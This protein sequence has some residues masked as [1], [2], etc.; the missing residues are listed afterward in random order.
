MC[1]SAG[2][3]QRMARFSLGA[4]LLPFGTLL[5]GSTI[6]TNNEKSTKVWTG[7]A[8]NAPVEL[9]AYNSD[10]TLPTNQVYDDIVTD[11]NITAPEV[12]DITDNNHAT[13]KYTSVDRGIT[14]MPNVQAQVV[15]VSLI[16][17]SD[18]SVLNVGYRNDSSVYG[19]Y[20]WIF[21]HT[22]GHNTS[23]VNIASFRAT[24]AVSI[25]DYLSDTVLLVGY[26][27]SSNTVSYVFVNT[28]T[29]SCTSVRTINSTPMTL[30]YAK[31]HESCIYFNGAVYYVNHDSTSTLTVSKFTLSGS[32]F[33]TLALAYNNDTN[34]TGSA[35][36]YLCK[37]LSES[38]NPDK[39]VFIGVSGHVKFWYYTIL[40][41]GESPSFSA[42]QYV[43]Q[44]SVDSQHN[45]YDPSVSTIINHTVNIDYLAADKSYCFCTATSSLTTNA[46]SSIRHPLLVRFTY[47]SS[48]N[49]LDLN[50]T[51]V[52]VVGW[53]RQVTFRT[54]DDANWIYVYYVPDTSASS[55][56]GMYLFAHNKHTA[57]FFSTYSKI[58]DK[59]SS[60]YISGWSASIHQYCKT[61]ISKNGYLILS[62]IPASSNGSGVNCC[63]VMSHYV[64][65]NSISLGFYPNNTSTKALAVTSGNIGDTVR[66]AYEGTYHVPGVPTGSIYNTD[67]S[68]AI[69]KK[70]GVLTVSEPQQTS[71]VYYGSYV[72]DGIKGVSASSPMSITFPFEPKVIWMFGY[73]YSVDL[74][75]MATDEDNP[76]S[77]ASTATKINLSRVTET[78]ENSGAWRSNTTISSVYHK[79]SSDRKTYYWHTNNPSAVNNI[80]N[81]Y[82]NEYWYI[83]F[84]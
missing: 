16:Q 38:G 9:V 58:T 14:T 19:T 22:S 54:V 6:G 52:N 53:E 41:L 74:A 1:S 69:A 78:F 33:D 37:Q 8:E 12:V 73:N 76:T 25:S 64:N 70:S 18:N 49:Q 81:Q 15:P 68:Y 28:K 31:Y 45:R 42:E 35:S 13:R 62:Y 32:T 67:T 57:E 79:L 5:T 83:A 23:Y 34:F 26:A 36:Y 55:S 17:I 48:T 43:D 10:G 61:A 63:A 46:P 27:G 29:L 40:T 66:I 24:N 56:T 80:F 30:M 84:G 50:T 47:D 44:T 59:G 39:V 7:D 82:L 77:T 65:N 60:Q 51:R 75:D 21:D 72:G 4:A 71:K 3:G 2:F 11:V 20:V